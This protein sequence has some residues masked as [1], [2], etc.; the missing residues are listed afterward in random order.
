VKRRRVHY[1]EQKI[2]RLRLSIGDTL[3]VHCPGERLDEIRSRRDF[4]ILEDIHQ[5]IVNQGKAPIAVAIFFMMIVVAST[6]G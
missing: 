6:P 5:G 2:G 1:S 3:L 4:I